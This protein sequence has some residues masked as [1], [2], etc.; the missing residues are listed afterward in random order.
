MATSSKV[1]F[2]LKT[3]KDKAIESIDFRIAQKKLE[4]DSFLDEAA[5]DQRV[6]DWRARQEERVS[7]LFRQLG[8]HGI[9]NHRLAKWEIEDIPSV[10]KWERSR[11]ERDLRELESRRSQIVAKSE[12]LV[13]DSDGKISLTSTQMKEFFD[14]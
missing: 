3:L 11:A 6:N 14:L 5:L 12:S 9:D 2:D 10:D 13:P 4:V 8:E 1:Y 7:E